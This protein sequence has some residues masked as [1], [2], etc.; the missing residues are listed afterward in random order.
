MLFFMTMK[1]VRIK[2]TKKECEQWKAYA[3]SLEGMFVEVMK[4]KHDYVNILSSISEYIR[5]KD[6]KG[7]EN[8]ERDSF[9]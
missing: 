7:L 9:A 8:M 5:I 4:F 6:I 2:N 1:E 3:E